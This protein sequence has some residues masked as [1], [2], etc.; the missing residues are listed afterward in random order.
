[1]I[2]YIPLK[3]VD[4]ISYPS[5]PLVS[6]KG[7][8]YQSLHL[9][10]PNSVLVPL[11]LVKKIGKGTDTYCDVLSMHSVEFVMNGYANGPHPH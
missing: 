8:L 11:F 2:N 1:M 10:S 9:H 6:L 5:P 3:T 7:T 4:V